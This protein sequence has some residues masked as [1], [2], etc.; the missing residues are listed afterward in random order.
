MYLNGLFSEVCVNQDIYFDDSRKDFARCSSFWVPTK[1]SIDNEVPD[2][3]CYNELTLMQACLG[4]PFESKSH[5]SG[6][7]NWCI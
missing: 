5:V 6:F 4:N 1:L 2:V 7:A 3:A